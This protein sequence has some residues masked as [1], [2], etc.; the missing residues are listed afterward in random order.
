MWKEMCDNMYIS[1]SMKERLMYENDDKIHYDYY[2]Q[3]IVEDQEIYD[4]EDY[5]YTIDDRVSFIYVKSVRINDKEFFVWS[6]IRT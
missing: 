3:R 6:S 2:T 5:A 1:R 4:N